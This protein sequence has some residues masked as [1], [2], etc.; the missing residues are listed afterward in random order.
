MLNEY[1]VRYKKKPEMHPEW[2]VQAADP[3]SAVLKVELAENLSNREKKALVAYEITEGQ[4]E[5]WRCIDEL[6]TREAIRNALRQGKIVYCSR[7]RIGETEESV[8]QVT[9][10][11]TDRSK[12][13]IVKTQEHGWIYPTMVFLQQPK[14][15]RLKDQ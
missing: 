1:V 11:V 2:Y 6:T 9:N 8:F 13:I 10:V 4:Q 5:H 15:A 3:V 14:G 12:R 7:L